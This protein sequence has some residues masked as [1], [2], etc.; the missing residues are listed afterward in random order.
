MKTVREGK[1]R[2]KGWRWGDWGLGLEKDIKGHL[3]TPV[4]RLITRKLGQREE[5]G[6][7]QRKV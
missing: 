1:A 6:F 3:Y 2:N 7:C 4:F 5:S